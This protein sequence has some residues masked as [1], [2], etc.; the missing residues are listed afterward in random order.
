MF[1]NSE[2]CFQSKGKFLKMFALSSYFLPIILSLQ[3]PVF[4]NVSVPLFLACFLLGPKS[5]SILSFHFSERATQEACFSSSHGHAESVISFSTCKDH[6]EHM[7]LSSSL[8][9]PTSDPLL[10]T[11][12][13]PQGAA[14]RLPLLPLVFLL[15]TML[16]RTT[17]A[18]VDDAPPFQCSCRQAEAS[19]SSASPSGTSPP[20]EAG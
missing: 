4:R 8:L 20:S 7:S 18:K 2:N 19:R 9:I 15:F 5:D 3:F 14:A 6:A 12:A 16:P 13:S 1:A 17:A 11:L 10:Q